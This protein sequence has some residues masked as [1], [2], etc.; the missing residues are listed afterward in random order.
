M[1][2]LG[3]VPFGHCFNNW[4]SKQTT[5]RKK[6]L[7]LFHSVSKQFIRS[8]I[9]YKQEGL[10]LR[11]YQ[12]SSRAPAVVLHYK[13][14]H[15]SSTNTIN[16][17]ERAAFSSLVQAAGQS[18]PVT[19]Q[20]SLPTTEENRIKTG[21]FRPVN[22]Q[23]V[24]LP[25]AAYQCQTQQPALPIKHF[26]HSHSVIKISAQDSHQEDILPQGPNAVPTSILCRSK[27]DNISLHTQIPFPTTCPRRAGTLPYP[28]WRD[29]FFS[30]AQSES[31][32]TLQ[33]QTQLEARQIS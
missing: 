24:E 14:T 16:I 31:R 12:L 5:S 10:L 11:K 9:T 4:A 21:S 3:S 18:S 20:P 2:P 30:W 25:D 6:H 28:S 13:H 7:L 29:L 19:L 23:D 27:V 26:P 15:F 22:T 33:Q 1:N 17:L 8:K 32:S